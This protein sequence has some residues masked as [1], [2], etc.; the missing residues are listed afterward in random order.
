MK[1]TRPT[2]SD[3]RG[4]SAWKFAALMLAAFTIVAVCA[5]LGGWAGLIGIVVTAVI[6]IG[7]AATRL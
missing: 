3:D 1:K 5:L 2:D 6:L 7:F 4:L